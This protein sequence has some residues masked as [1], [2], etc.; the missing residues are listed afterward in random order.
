MSAM[1][2]AEACFRD[3]P[4]SQPQWL[5]LAQAVHNGQRMSKEGETACGG[6]LRWQVFSRM[7]VL[8]HYSPLLLCFSQVNSLSTNSETENECHLLTLLK[9]T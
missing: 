1:L 3:P 9:N 6:G 7:L 4:P 8:H 5:A 2:A